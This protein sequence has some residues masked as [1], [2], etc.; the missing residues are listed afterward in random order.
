M[1]DKRLD[2]LLEHLPAKILESLIGCKYCIE[3]Q[4]G[5]FCIKRMKNGEFPRPIDCHGDV[6]KCE[7]EE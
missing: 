3:D 5:Y 2:I 7:L 4:N 1:K 6:T